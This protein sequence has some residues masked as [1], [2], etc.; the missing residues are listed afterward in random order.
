VT[1]RTYEVEDG[2]CRIADGNDTA[3]TLPSHAA[4][5][6]PLDNPWI[7]DRGKLLLTAGFTDADGA[8]GA[9]LVPWALITG[10]G[11][12]SSYGA[13]AHFTGIHLNDFDLRT[14]GVGIGVF[15]RFELSYTRQHLKVTGTALDGISIDQD[16]FGAKLRLVGDAIYGQDS[17][18][19]Q[20]A[21]G[22]ESKRN[23][24]IDDASKIGMPGLVDVRQLG[25]K[26]QNG[27]DFY[28]NATK[29][30][31]EQSLVVNLT[32]RYTKANQFGLLGFGGDRDDGYSLQVEGTV[33]YLFTR[34]LAAGAEYR[35]RPRNL[36]VDKEADAWDVFVAWAPFRAISIVGAYVN[37]G[38]I[39]APVTTK[40]TTQ[41]GPYVSLQAG[42]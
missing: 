7:P 32:A 14:Y 15:D 4:S 41:R 10:Y 34:K 6:S 39:L 37:V 35:S 8:G 3:V 13:N 26:D 5:D 31:L 18:L 16:I 29:I 30:Y 24:G 2:E 11:S 25:A 40:T 28:L 22:V 12:A 20:I 21:V 23:R 17:W 19:P 42:F 36:S 38:S 9:G 33:G 27:T 1:G